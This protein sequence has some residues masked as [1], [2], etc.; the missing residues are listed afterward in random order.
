MKFIFFEM[1]NFLHEF[2]WIQ[3]WLRYNTF[4]Q[5]TIL[6]TFRMHLGTMLILAHERDTYYLR[7]R[8]VY[9]LRLGRGRRNNL[10]IIDKNIYVIPTTRLRGTVMSTCWM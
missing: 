9:H 5:T 1:C 7:D 2:I 4:V 10:I 3:N 8:A 6:W